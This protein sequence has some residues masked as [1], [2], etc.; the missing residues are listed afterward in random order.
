[1]SNFLN[2]YRKSTTQIFIFYLPKFEIF[3]EKHVSLAFVNTM[4]ILNILYASFPCQK[5]LSG[6][7]RTTV[8]LYFWEIARLQ[9]KRNL[10]TGVIY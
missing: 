2:S 1:M 5:N 3:I 10:D 9:T 7:I 6:L 8:N 4:L